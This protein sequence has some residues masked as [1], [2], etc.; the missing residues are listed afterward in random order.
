MY[1]EVVP[2]ILADHPAVEWAP[3]FVPALVLALGLFAMVL[4]ERRRGR[5][6]EADH[7]EH[8]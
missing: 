1:H 3:F 6:G 2:F 8:P 4:V 5:L 7:D